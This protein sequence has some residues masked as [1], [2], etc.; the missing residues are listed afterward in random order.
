[1]KLV[2]IGKY[3]WPHLG[4]MERAL[5]D[6]AEGFL[7]EGFDV[8][9]VVSHQKN[10]LQVDVVNGVTVHRMPTIGRFFNLP[11]TKWSRSY[12][13]GLS[14]DILNIHLPNPI[15]M[16]VFNTLD[17]KKIYTLHTNRV[18]S[19]IVNFFHNKY[20]LWTLK[21]HKSQVIVTSQYLRQWLKRR[22]ILSETVPLA[23]QS[24][25]MV[26]NN[27]VKK[28]DLIFVGR[29][30][31]YKGIPILIKALKDTDKSLLIVGDGPKKKQLL[32]LIKSF[33]I[34]HRVKIVGEKRGEALI[35]CI[36][37]SRVMVLPSIN[38]SEAF[39]LCL[40]EGMRRGLPLITTRLDSG[41]R[42]VNT[43]G[44]TGLEALPK[45]ANSLKKAIMEILEDDL[46]YENYSKNCYS[47]MSTDFCFNG[48]IKS[49]VEKLNL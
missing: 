25:P 24:S 49:Y 26:K 9:V 28:Y 21:K 14:P 3:Y 39:G 34:Q 36:D 22:N 35:K 32:K 17:F 33:G 44:V 16:G 2:L 37:E 7:K 45:N 5:Q 31:K 23:I 42:E 27:N 8:H 13:K 41:V 48:Y 4:G 47:R 10:Q 46:N 20:L 11:I 12:I 15:A 38:S 18:S 30:V 1:M 29:L 40:L 43:V 6:L 19:P